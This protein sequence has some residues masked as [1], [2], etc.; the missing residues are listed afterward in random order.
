M[1]ESCILPVKGDWILWLCQFGRTIVLHN[2]RV[3]SFPLFAS[4]SQKRGWGNYL[5]FNYVPSRNGSSVWSYYHWLIE[6]ALTNWEKVPSSSHSYARPRGKRNPKLW[7][8]R[9]CDVNHKGE[10]GQEDLPCKVTRWRRRVWSGRRSCGWRWSCP[11]THN[12]WRKPKE[13]E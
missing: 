12:V 5:K 13:P 4:H 6:I 8:L 9:I 2:I 10:E 1:Q 11:L 3:W 7:N